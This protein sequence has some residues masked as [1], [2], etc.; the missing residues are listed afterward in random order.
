MQLVLFFIAVLVI[1]SLVM[2]GYGIAASSPVI[3]ILFA[4]LACVFMGSGFMIR[5]KIDNRNQK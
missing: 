5:R 2:I 1:A 4:V 3:G